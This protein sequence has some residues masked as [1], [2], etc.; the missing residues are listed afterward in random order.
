MDAILDSFMT[1]TPAMHVQARKALFDIIMH[2]VYWLGK[3]GVVEI[4]G[5]IAEFNSVSEAYPR[6][7]TFGHYQEV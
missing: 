3:L 2:K 7:M 6:E 1:K 5:K 4:R